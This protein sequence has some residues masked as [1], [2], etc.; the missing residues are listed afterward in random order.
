[1]F[2][3]VRN[4]KKIIQIVLALIILP[5]AFWGVDSYVRDAG[6]EGTV[7]SVG[8]SKISGQEFQQAV[9]EEQDRM[10]PALG[11]KVDPAM[12]DNPQMRAAVLDNLINQRLLALHADKLKLGVSNAQ[13]AQFIGAVPS[14]QENGKFSKERYEALVAA[15]GM[16]IEMFEARVRKDLVMRQAMTPLTEASLPG[17]SAADRW[18]A[19][20]L[21][22]REIAEAILRPEQYID[23]VKL[24][25]DAAKA[26]Y[27]ANKTQFE[28]PEQIRVEY[29]TLSRS[30]M[31]AQATTDEK[32]IRAWYEAHADRYRKPEERRASHILIRADKSAPP[33]DLKAAEA[34][35]AEILTEL[36]KP[37]ADFAKLA[38]QHSQD[39]GSGNQG[40]DLGWFGRGMMVKP[41]EEAAFGLKE[42]EL[43]GAVRSDFGIHVIKLTGIRPEKIRPIEEVRGEIAAEIKR[44]AAMKKYA[45]AAE[46]FANT[47]YEQADSLKPAAEKF[48]LAIQTSGWLAKGAQPDAPFSNPKL[49]AAL[50]SDDA[51]KNR[52][53]T[54]AVEVAPNTLM[55]ARVVEHKPATM[56]PLESVAPAI[57]KLLLRQEAA[58]LAAKDGEEKL[59]R[60]ARGEAVVLPWSPVRTVSRAHAPNLV[61]ESLRAI[62]KPDATA[63]LPAH[64][65]TTIPGGYALYRI[66]GI[67]PYAEGEGAEPPR[68]QKL[69][70]QYAQIVAQEEFAAWIAA[71]KQRYP[72]EINKAALESKQ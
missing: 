16:S 24:A 57:E 72:V 20:Q 53:N 63:K 26:Y 62:F 34:R 56:E 21:E 67:K 51:L 39:P 60:L 42:G 11:G 13:L 3:A 27:E 29:L 46:A 45:E 41:F 12:L 55:S 28:R 10:R 54:E 1:M 48:G 25:P 35:I 37:G 70:Q 38:K 69:R 59:A 23:Q 33:A 30:A 43:S 66:S 36:K 64:A 5:F 49:V 18:I 58:K 7:A 15:Q 40:G 31:E 61:P 44:E 6:G 32:A 71:L 68:A 52:R 19:T 14:L 65:G 2:D 47:V 4:N 50:F 8:G 22:E 17:R 9:R